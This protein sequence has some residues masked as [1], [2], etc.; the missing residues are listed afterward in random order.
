MANGGLVRESEH[1]DA[2]DHGSGDTTRSI[3]FGLGSAPAAAAQRINPI[4][5]ADDESI[6]KE[7]PLEYAVDMNRLIQIQMEGSVG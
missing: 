5:E 3:A 6:V 2:A 4:A 7:L 1:G